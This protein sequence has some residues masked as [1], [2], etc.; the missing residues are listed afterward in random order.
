[1][2]GYSYTKAQAIAWLG[3]VGKDKSATMFSSL[4]SAKLN[5][6]MSNEHGCVDPNGRLCGPYRN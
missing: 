6:L 4:V 3:K 1:M 2:R 5:V